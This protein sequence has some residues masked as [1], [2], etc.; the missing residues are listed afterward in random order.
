MRDYSIYL[1]YI[2]SDQ[3][4]VFIKNIFSDADFIRIIIGYSE[5]HNGK[6]VGRVSNKWILSSIS[7]SDE[8]IFI[9][10]VNKRMMSGRRMWVTLQSMKRHKPR[11]IPIQM[12]LATS[13]PVSKWRTKIGAATHFEV[14]AVNS[15]RELELAKNLNNS[16]S[17][18]VCNH[19]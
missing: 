15:V 11:S 10:E 5:M 9:Q 4:Q 17:K 8:P 1:T 19:E 2:T 12:Y 16:N 14:K 6:R 7:P 3:Y 18:L 13:P